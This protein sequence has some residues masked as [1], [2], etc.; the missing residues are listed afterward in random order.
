MTL[1]P[2]GDAV[3]K[4]SLLSASMIA[5]VGSYAV[6]ADQPNIIFI[7]TDQQT[8]DAMSNRGNPWV[9][10]PAMDELAK[11][12]VT[13]SKAYCSYPLSGPSRASIFTGKMPNAVQVLEN[14]DPLPAQEIPKSLG[15]RMKNQGYDCLYAGKWHVPTVNI[16]DK[17][18]GFKKIC[19]MNDPKMAEAIEKELSVKRDKPVFLVASYLNPHEICEYARFQTLHY[20]EVKIPVNAK[21]P[22]LPDNFKTTKNLPEQLMLHKEVSPKLYP[23]RNYTTQDWKNYMYAYY[24]LVERVDSVISDLISI[25]KEK[26]LYDNSIIIFTSDHGDGVAAHKWNQKRALFEETIHIPLIVKPAKNHPNTGKTNEQSLVNIGLDIYSTICDYAGISLP[27]DEYKGKSL[28][29]VLNDVSKPLHESIMVETHLD[30]I[31]GRAWCVI[32]GDYKYVYYRFFKNKEQLFNLRTDKGEKKNLINKKG[33]E[34]IQKEMKNELRKHA[35][36]H[37][38]KM[39]AK[40]LGS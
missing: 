38:D 3:V 12:G 15:F 13:F 16:P 33:L 2:L 40:E 35:K 11:D 39:L 30:G 1:K 14:N 5:G 25:L 20:G 22:P 10:T 24:R 18:F 28:R 17:E 7:M 34:L 36:E 21:Y 29:P 23:T 6:A 4:G 19:D 37:G 8:A 31:N 32:K 26:E 9:K 27:A